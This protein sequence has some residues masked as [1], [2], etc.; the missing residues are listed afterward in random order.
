MNGAEH[1]SGNSR[2]SILKTYKLF[3]GGEF[4]RTES[5]RYTKFGKSEAAPVA[6]VCRASRKDLR[7]AVV[8][9]RKS[10]PS[11]ASKTAYNRS[12]I[13]YRIAEN[14]ES[15]R[16]QLS[17]TLL[18]EGL[19]ATSAKQNVEQCID[20]MVYY[21]GWADKYQ[22]VFSSVNP[23]AAPYFNFSFPE[24]NGVVAALAPED[25]SLLA[26]VGIIAPILCGGNT[27]VLLASE[28]HPMSA[29]EFAEVVHASDV[30][31]G[32][33]NILTGFE[34]ELLEQISLH[35]DINAIVSCNT[36]AS[37][38]KTIE[39]NASSNLKRTVFRNVK[40]WSDAGCCNPYFIM[41]TQEIKTTW[42]PLGN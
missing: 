10:Q 2:V 24:A 6:N 16:E 30:P 41:D 15:R 17:S 29:I 27:A 1:K 33:L 37:K 31:A 35:M 14:L 4:L 21:A 32:V 34:D 25:G 18:K 22:Q 8:A 20:R 23:V 9:A 19:T 36:S 3:I 26:L 28:Q 39:E 13:L 5:G 42:H 12:Q 40:N 11:W 7:N 38:L